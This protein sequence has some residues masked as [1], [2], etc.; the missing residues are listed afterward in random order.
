MDDSK[1]SPLFFWGTVIFLGYLGVRQGA[2][3]TTMI[4]DKRGGGPR[5]TKSTLKDGIVLEPASKLA[6]LAGV[7]VSVY[8]LAR[9]LASE[10]DGDGVPVKTAIAW[11]C[12][13]AARKAKVDVFVLLT[14][15]TKMS[16]GSFGAQNTGR[17]ASTAR[18]PRRIDCQIAADVLSWKVADPTGGATQFDSPRAQR[19]LMARAAKGYTKSPEQVAEARRKGGSELVTIPGVDP[20]Y[21]RF[22]RPKAN[23]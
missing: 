2:A 11:A 4:A 5:V 23:A 14:R 10:H 13:N 20:D 9:M 7:N 6:A 3:L 12:V 22:W 21:L 18:D 1:P 15:S 8:A 19:A 17:Y 16:P